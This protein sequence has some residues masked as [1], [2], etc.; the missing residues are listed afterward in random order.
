R[1]AALG[2]LSGHEAL[3]RKLDRSLEF[4]DSQIARDNTL[5]SWDSGLA[6]TQAAIDST[7]FV[8]KMAKL[9]YD[10]TEKGTKRT[11]DAVEESLWKFQVAGLAVGGDLLAAARGSLLASYAAAAAANDAFNFVQEFVGGA[12]AVAKENALQLKEA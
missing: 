3:K 7:L 4:F 1:N 6:E 10:N 8:V 9:L 2:T 5:N 12:F 11:V